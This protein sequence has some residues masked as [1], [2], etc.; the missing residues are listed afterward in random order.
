[1]IIIYYLHV[2]Q[3]PFLEAISSFSHSAFSYFYD[4]L[5]LNMLSFFLSTD[6][7]RGLTEGDAESEGASAHERACRRGLEE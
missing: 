4:M 2:R 3:N 7:E 6:G 5:C 1:M